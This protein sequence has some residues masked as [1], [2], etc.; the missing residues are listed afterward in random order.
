[1][2]ETMVKPGIEEQIG[3]ALNASVLVM[4]RI[5]APSAETPLTRIA[6]I[7]A[8]A[9]RIARNA[10]TAPANARHG[11]ARPGDG[12]EARLAPLLWRLK[13]GGDAT[14]ETALDAAR[15]FRD[16]LA[17]HPFCIAHGMSADG[18]LLLRFAARMLYEW[19]A[20]KC[21]ACAG[22]GLQELLRGGVVRRPRTFAN[23]KVRHVTCRACFGTRK[24]L[25]NKMERSRAL[26]ISLAE[27][28]ARWPRRFHLGAAWI[29][30]ITRRLKS[31]LNCELERCINPNCR[32]NGICQ[33]SL[34]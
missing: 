7:G 32:R 29:E 16:W 23:P 19:I 34:P 5:E 22:T 25:P 14:Q 31:P 21:R 9:G 15:L 1:M 4:D 20:D 13:F 30:R 27:Y 2:S 33:R 3:V 8:A 10:D 28:D 6:A 11:H 24:Q 17:Q 26:E 18:V 12:L